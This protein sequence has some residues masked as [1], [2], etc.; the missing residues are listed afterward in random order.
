MGHS[1]LVPPPARVNNLRQIDNP[2]HTR[3]RRYPKLTS[4]ALAAGSIR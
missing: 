4:D 2:P 3:P 1:L